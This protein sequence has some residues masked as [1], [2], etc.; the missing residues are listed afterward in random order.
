[1]KSCSQQGRKHGEEM[2]KCWLLALFPVLTMFQ[3]ASLL[4]V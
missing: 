4:S 2:T 1:M 3:K